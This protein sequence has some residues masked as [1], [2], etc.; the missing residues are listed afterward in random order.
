MTNDILKTVDSSDSSLNSKK[1]IAILLTGQL[2]TWR[3]CKGIINSFKK[4][5]N[6]DI[7]MSVDLTNTQQ[8]EWLNST[9]KT[10]LDELKEAIEFY[11]P[12]N[13]YYSENYK[14]DKFHKFLSKIHNCRYNQET[15]YNLSDISKIAL[16]NFTNSDSLIYEKLFNRENKSKGKE[17]IFNKELLLVI[18]QQYYFVYKAYTLLEN[19]LNLN[20]KDYDVII[21]L[22]FDQYILN[23]KDHHLLIYDYKYNKSYIN[24]FADFYNNYKF[25]IL[26]CE[27]NNIYVINGGL[28]KN[29]AYVNDQF[30]MHGKKMIQTMKVFYLQLPRIINNC[31]KT[32]WPFNRYCWIEHFFACYLTQKKI[33]IKK[34]KMT[35][36]F[37]REKQI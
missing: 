27:D 6:V 25:D 21:R 23:S 35:G 22:R 4:H 2:R 7:F 28:Y 16:S 17:D 15:D 14:R 1:K 32:F 12:V 19:H 8:H 5:F 37:I 33:I 20:N 11:K 9:A 10:N 24:K 3:M 30:Y 31:F 34:S 18:A 36:I 26:D 13:Y 29:Y